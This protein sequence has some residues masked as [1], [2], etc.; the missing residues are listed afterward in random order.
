MSFMS[1]LLAASLAVPQSQVYPSAKAKLVRCGEVPCVSVNGELLPPMSFTAFM[2]HR[3]HDDY[4][5]DV[6]KAMFASVMRDG[7]RS[8]YCANEFLHRDL[9]AK[10]A[11]EA[12]CHL[13]TKPGDVLYA[14]ENFVTL[15]ATGD[16]KRTV[17]LKRKCS[18][19]EVYEKRFYG[20]DVDT[21]EVDLKNGETRMWRL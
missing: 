14:S 4:L 8:V 19:Y 1:L 3:V 17:R 21:I 9:V 18:P 5:R 15:H 20:Q 10:L 6:G 11:E 16:G 7:V 12:G 2:P 13:F